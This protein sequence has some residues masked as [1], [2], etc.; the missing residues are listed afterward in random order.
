MGPEGASSDVDV[1]VIG[2]GNAAMCAALT[3]RRLGRGVVVLERALEGSRGGNTRHTR[4]IRHAHEGSDAIMM[5]SYSDEEFWQDLRRVSGDAVNEELARLTIRESRFCPSFM[6]ANGIRWQAPLRGT[7]HLSRTNRFFLGGGKALI[8]DYYATA[9]GLGVDI[10]YGSP[11]VRLEVQESHCVGV[12]IERDGNEETLRPKA[13]VVAAGGFEANIDWLSEYWGEAARNF[14]VRGTALND[15]RLLRILLDL[16]SRSVG[17]PKGAHAIAVDARSPKFDGG[18]VTRI[19]SIPLG[20]VVNR[21]GLRFADEGEDLWPRRYASWGR[22]IAEQPEQIAYS[23]FDAQV[24]GSF[25][26]GVYPPLRAQGVSELAELIG[27]DPSVLDRTV[28]EFNAGIPEGRR[29]DAADLDGCATTGVQPPKSNWAQR[30]RKP[31]FFAYPL[32]PGV[33]F[34]YLGVAV[35]SETR[36]LLDRGGRFAN[37]FAAGEIMAGNVLTRGYIAGIGLTI[38]TVFGRIAGAEAA[39]IAAA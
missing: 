22:L 31:P 24:N 6:E 1:I 37:V 39:R 26:P 33:T 13:I 8:N 28:M 19:D 27:V 29:I 36:V 20:I 15:G 34:T 23:I 32:R 10:R 17:D 16:G 38:G 30:L 3:A 35:D 18:I 12:V 2:G 4:N 11:V 7:L 14:I 21:D 9:L 25:I 5:G